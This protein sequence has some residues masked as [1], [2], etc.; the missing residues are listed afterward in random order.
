MSYLLLSL[1]IAFLYTHA[2]IYLSYAYAKRHLMQ[3]PHSR[4]THTRT[5]PRGVG[6]AVVIVC[7]ITLMALYLTPAHFP[8]GLAL[9]LLIGGFLIAGIGFVDDHR[10]VDP[11]IRL[12]VQAIA[13][14]VVLY[15]I[16][17]FPDLYLFNHAFDWGWA[18]SFIAF[19]GM[20]WFINLYNFTDG[21]DGLAGMQTLFVSL[22]LAAM[23]FLLSILSISWLML[24]LATAISA[25][26]FWNWQPAKVFMGDVCSG[27]LGF[28]F[29][30]LMAY[31]ARDNMV[32][33]LCWFILL[34]MPIVDMSYT[35]VVRL[36][37]GYSYK[38]AHCTHA[39]QH[40]VLRY[41]SHQAV[42]LRGLMVNLFWLAPFAWAAFLWPQY[43]VWFFCL[44]VPPIFYIVI[45]L[46]AGQENDFSKTS[47]KS[48][49]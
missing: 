46:G 16:G 42:V 38:Q 1:L 45:K 41:G 34:A 8:K 23:T 13:V 21:I 7:L 14:G 49:S 35:L 3:A 17:G 37:K 40:A 29:A 31:T 15:Q 25:F 22:N 48:S 12:G 36:L 2:L 47:L 39:F 28:L 27:F 20:L 33:I 30:G 43:D 6:L 18:G 24:I 19:I 5:I 9:S 32:P 26:L 10:S 4:G 44:A 11:V